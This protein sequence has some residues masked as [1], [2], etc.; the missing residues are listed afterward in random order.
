[1]ATPTFS[2]AA[3]TL[4]IPGA[5][6]INCAT[7]GATIRY[8][9]DGNIP[10]GASPIYEGPIP[11]TAPMTIKAKAYKPTMASSAVAT[12][13][14]TATLPRPEFASEAGTLEKIVTIGCTVVGVTIRYTTTGAEPTATSPIAVNGTVVVNKNMTLKAK[15]F[16]TGWLVSPTQTAIYTIT[17]VATPTF[18]PPAGILAI[19]GA[20]SINSTTPDATIFYTTDGSTPT[21]TST[22]YE[23]PIPFTAPMVIKAKAYKTDMASSPVASGTFNAALPIP[24][25]T[26]EA[27]TLVKTVTITCSVAGVTIRYT[28][29][30]YEPTATSPIAVNGTVLV[31]KN[32]TLK[33]KA[34]K[35]G[36]LAS[37][38]QTAIYTITQV[39]TPIFTPVAGTYT[40]AKSVKITCATVGATVRYTTNGDEPTP[41]SPICTATTVISVTAS[42]TLKAKA[43]KT[44]MTDSNT[45]VAEYTITGTVAT[46]I[47]YCISKNLMASQRYLCF[48]A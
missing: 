27:G 8:T 6:T 16:K 34:F 19:P 43:Y 40:A 42:K 33:A 11:F 29:N 21:L 38:T 14:Y 1:M 31:N 32:M 7:S 24:E 36:W 41:S 37:P 13:T 12:K 15:A 20:I 23:G 45:A 9:T 28:T 30:G 4:T 3:G 10:T 47:F 48:G 2:P 17:P 5:I 46:P 25:F 39:I 26:S 35:T 22:E 44:G 18:S